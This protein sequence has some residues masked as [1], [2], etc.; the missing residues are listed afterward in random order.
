MKL[1]EPWEQYFPA[2]QTD[3]VNVIPATEQENPAVIATHCELAAA[4]GFGE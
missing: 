4:F 2:V 3:C 1:E